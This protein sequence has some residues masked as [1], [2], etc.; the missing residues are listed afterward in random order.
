MYY[1]NVTCKYDGEAGSLDPDLK[2][3]VRVLLKP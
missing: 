2:H 1:V 3:F